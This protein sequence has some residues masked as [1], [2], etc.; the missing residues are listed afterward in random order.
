MDLLGAG[1]HRVSLL[2]PDSQSG[3]GQKE[4]EVQAT[5][6]LGQVVFPENNTGD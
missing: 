1:V 4:P 3:G 5:G 6:E 2:P